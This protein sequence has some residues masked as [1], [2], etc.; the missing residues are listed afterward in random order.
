[1]V[2]A[3][4]EEL[5]V[6]LRKEKPIYFLV[7]YP[8]GMHEVDGRKDVSMESPSQETTLRGC[9]NFLDLS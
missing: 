2:R 3:T 6:Q 5:S 4:R 8:E 9:I 1:M 7:L